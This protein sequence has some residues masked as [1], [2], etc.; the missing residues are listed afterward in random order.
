MPFREKLKRI[1][2]R[3]K[4]PVPSTK[5][6]A[7]QSDERQGTPVNS[8]PS[9]SSLPANPSPPVNSSPSTSVQ[10]APQTLSLQASNTPPQTKA[11]N[12]GA[13]VA[14]PASEPSKAPKSAFD[15]AVQ[16]LDPE[17]RAAFKDAKTPE[18]I[19]QQARDLGE[20]HKESTEKLSKGLEIVTLSINRF[21]F[22]A[23][24]DPS[25]V[26]PL[27]MGGVKCIM[28]IATNYISYFDRLVGIILN[29]E[30]DILVDV[31]IDVLEFCQKIRSMFTE[32]DGSNTK[33]PGFWQKLKLSF[34]GQID[35]ETKLIQERL[36]K[37]RDLVLETA[38]A[39]ILSGLEEQGKADMLRWV[40][41]ANHEK[42]YNDNLRRKHEGTANWLLDDPRFQTWHKAPNGHALWCFGGPGMGKT[43]IASNVIN[44]IKVQSSL[45]DNVGIAFLF[46]QYDDMK[47]FDLPQFLQQMEP[48]QSVKVIMMSRPLADIKEYL[49]DVPS[50]QIDALHVYEDVKLYVRESI[51][52]TTAT[53]KNV[54]ML[55]R[56][57]TFPFGDADFKEELISR[58]T[59]MSKGM[60]LWVHLQI[61]SLFESKDEVTVR[62]KLQQLPPDLPE[63]YERMLY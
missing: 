41:S 19:L 39:K 32:S 17:A 52:G 57:T 42:E 11:S 27:V 13:L 24:A 44:Y 36:K 6:T 16:Q 45:D 7:P 29:L 2:R 43:V 15:R 14:K 4:R 54:Q 5:S 46:C 30:E 8:R 28:D 9:N 25:S 12:D 31:Y 63:T 20:S 48:L 23:S 34:S 18:K 10:Q 21:Q 40:S 49:K 51:E 3:K 60:F 38:I 58:L 1:W 53:E 47:K 62:K 56:P 61:R 22:L 35:S 50:I 55:S 26:A 59:E 37:H 33:G